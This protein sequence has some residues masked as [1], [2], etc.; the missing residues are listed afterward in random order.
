MLYRTSRVLT[1]GELLAF[2]R[3]QGGALR[4]TDAVIEALVEGG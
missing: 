2:H 3:K 4:T 1:A